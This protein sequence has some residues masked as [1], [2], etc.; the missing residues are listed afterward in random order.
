MAPSRPFICSSRK[1]AFIWRNHE[2]PLGKIII[3]KNED[4]YLIELKQVMWYVYIYILHSY[5]SLYIDIKCSSLY[6]I[7]ICSSVLSDVYILIYTYN[8]F[9]YAFFFFYSSNG[10][11]VASC[12]L[13]RIQDTVKSKGRKAQ[14]LHVKS[15]LQKRPPAELP[16]LRSDAAV[17]R[18]LPADCAT[19]APSHWPPEISVSYWRKCRLA[20][21]ERGTLSCAYIDPQTNLGQIAQGTW[22]KIPVLQRGHA[23][24]ASEKGHQSTYGHTRPVALIHPYKAAAGAG[25]TCA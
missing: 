9:A 5:I 24:C 23:H 4:I 21:K 2:F 8:Y 11:R 1:A 25:P 17:H 6:T 7:Y 13:P 10:E 22:Q 3:G 19:A 18:S 20:G 15:C 12:T 14:E 16:R